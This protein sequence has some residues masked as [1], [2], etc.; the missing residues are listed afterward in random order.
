M[1]EVLIFGLKH[2]I[3]SINESHILQSYLII[4]LLFKFQICL[5]HTENMI[6]WSL[7]LCLRLVPLFAHGSKCFIPG[8]AT[9]ELLVCLSM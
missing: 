9:D 5:C 7:K 3:N 2:F 8:R 6:R 1:G 4:F